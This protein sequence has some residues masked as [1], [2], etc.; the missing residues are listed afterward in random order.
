M[1]EAVEI[2][3]T[4]IKNR[5]AAHRF[6]PGN[7]G[8]PKGSRNKFGQDFIDAIADDFATHGREVLAKVR[9][10]FPVAYLKIA[11]A[12][13]PK[14]L[15]IS[16]DQKGGELIDA[17]EGLDPVSGNRVRGAGGLPLSAG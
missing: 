17:I 12:L 6:K 2:I 8:R 3:T 10:E 7:P 1:S 4:E 16:T 11:A 9:Q 5:G 13:V 14:R 15:E